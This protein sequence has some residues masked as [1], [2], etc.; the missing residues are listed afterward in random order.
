M[1]WTDPSDHYYVRVW[2]S[3]LT[4]HPELSVRWTHDARLPATPGHGVITSALHWTSDRA[5]RPGDLEILPFVS[6]S[7]SHVN[8]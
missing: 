4:D 7:A 2:G 3:N 6:T 1:T 8:R 5:T